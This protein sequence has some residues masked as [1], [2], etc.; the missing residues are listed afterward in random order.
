MKTEEQF[1]E[2]LLEHAQNKTLL[3]I[4]HRLT[5]SNRLDRII[6]LDILHNLNSLPCPCPCPCPINV[7]F[8]PFSRLKNNANRARA[9]AGARAR[10]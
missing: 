10:N 1:M 7:V 4:T 5:I 9:G 3:L 6:R 8:E 2:S